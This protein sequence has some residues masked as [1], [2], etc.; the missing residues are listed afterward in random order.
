MVLLWDKRSLKEPSFS[1]TVQS[2]PAP[3]L[4]D[5][6]GPDGLPSG[7]PDPSDQ[8]GEEEEETTAAGE[9]MGP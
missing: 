4:W 1:S 7:T 5:Q 9:H 8:R 2:G 6:H 3:Q